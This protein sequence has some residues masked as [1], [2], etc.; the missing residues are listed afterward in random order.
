MAARRCWPQV[1]QAVAS[2]LLAALSQTAADLR[3][4]DQLM[5]QPTLDVGERL[6]V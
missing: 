3:V 6:E 5:A 1:V 2:K 4:L